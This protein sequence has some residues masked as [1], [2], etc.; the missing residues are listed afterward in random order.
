MNEDDL[1][2]DIPVSATV[3]VDENGRAEIVSREVIKYSAMDMVD[4]LDRKLCK[5]ERE[6][7]QRQ[8]HK[9]LMEVLK[10]G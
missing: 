6:E 3:Q 5:P 2:I 4:F 7:Y 9:W 1:T 8:L 10:N